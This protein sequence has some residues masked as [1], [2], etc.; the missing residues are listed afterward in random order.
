[1]TVVVL[2]DMAE[3]PRIPDGVEVLRV[4]SAGD[5]A[6]NVRLADMAEMLPGRV[7]DRAKDLAALAGYVYWADQ[8]VGRGGDTDV[9]GD[10][11]CRQFEV[12][13]P[14]RDVQFWRREE[15]G[16]A[17]SETL[18]AGTGDTWRFRFFEA[19]PGEE[20]FMFPES[21]FKPHDDADC[22]L[23][24]SGGADSLASAVKAVRVD[25]LH[26]VLVSHSPN[27]R[28]AGRQRKL[29]DALNEVETSWRFLQV[30]F[31]VNKPSR[32]EKESTQRTRGF[33]YASLGAATAAG[34]GLRDL[35]MSDNG[36]VSLGLPPNGGV[37]GSMASRT[38]HTM[39]FSAMNRLLSWVAPG[40]RVRNTLW[41]QTR[42]DALGLLRNHRCE[43]LLKLTNSCSA[44]WAL[45]EDKPHCG[46]CSQ[47]F[48]RRVGVVAK[49]LQA[50]DSGYAHDVFREDLQGSS[51]TLGE[52]TVRSA[53]R[54]AQWSAKD[55]LVEL[56]EVLDCING[57][58]SDSEAYLITVCEMVLR[59]A[60]VMRLALALERGRPGAVF[61]PRSLLGLA[62][63]E[64]AAPPMAD[65][66]LPAAP[67]LSA[68]AQSAF[69][70][71]GLRSGL[72]V[73]ILGEDGKATLL[74]VE[75]RE[76]RLTPSYFLLFLRLVVAL[77]E[78]ADAYEF[79]GDEGEQ[80][81]ALE[82]WFQGDSMEGAVNKLRER[83]HPFLGQ[84]KHTDFI[85]IS[86][87]R[88]RLSTA[89]ELIS[90][91]RN[92]LLEH[93]NRW[94]QEFAVRLPEK[95]RARQRRG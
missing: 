77:F 62:G 17:L 40:V 66:S 67:P 19:S 31:E 11:W 7:P 45:S 56:P 9:F 28:A 85:Q 32:T 94:V 15:V 27:H 68:E 91:D 73:E 43:H 83:L 89:R 42:A 63:S 8:M 78:K 24:F 86:D 79:L 12:H 61:G 38:T 76:V 20:Q 54:V 84:T 4:W 52:A 80:G 21:G 34:L 10:G 90:F 18:H 3:E 88:V 44:G 35:I 47:C 16:A 36:I 57:D 50:F 46:R 49:G 92:W 48:D 22:V 13:A 69:K 41:N 60:S 30:P 75:G 5:D 72:R 81:L 64:Q 1:M 82:E 71:Y 55:V 87:R 6:R 70:R 74:A 26:P 29:I 53:H 25:G 58:A 59:Q 23:M 2:C 37:I 14:V 95:A 33:L 65:V 39:F 93:H 51:L